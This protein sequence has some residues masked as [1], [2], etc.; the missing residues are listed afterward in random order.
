VQFILKRDHARRFRFAS[1]QSPFGQNVLSR[2]GL[3]PK[4]FHSLILVEGDNIY[5]RSDA[6]IRIFSALRG[7]SYVRVFRFV[8]RILRDGVYNLVARNRYR[9]FGQRDQ[10]MIPTPDLKSR[11]IEG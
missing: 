1:L 10:C 2:N 5:Q 8:P 3:D 11:F 9:L 4:A 6:A 7:F